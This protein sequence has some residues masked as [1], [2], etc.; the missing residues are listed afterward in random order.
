MWCRSIQRDRG[1][2]KTSF[3]YRRQTGAMPSGNASLCLMDMPLSLRLMVSERVLTTALKIKRS[4]TAL[5]NILFC[6]SNLP[7]ANV[8]SP[9]NLFREIT[10]PLCLTKK[11]IRELTLKVRYSAQTR[12]LSE[13]GIRHTL[14]PDGSPVVLYSAL[15]NLMEQPKRE[16]NQPDF[17]SLGQ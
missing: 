14:R 7:G 17:S 11:E 6:T 3:P 5:L 13:M 8:F 12:I 4:L 9:S 10:L 1:M 15:S 16:S 2:N